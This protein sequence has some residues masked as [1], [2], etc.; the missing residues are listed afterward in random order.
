[1]FGLATDGKANAQGLPNLLQLMVL[2]KIADSYTPGGL[3]LPVLKGIIGV[4]A[5]LGKAMGYRARYAR[6]SE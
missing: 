2:A 1:M 4:L 3:P 5:W 6:Y